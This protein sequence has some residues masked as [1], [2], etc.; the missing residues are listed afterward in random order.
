MA[1]TAAEVMVVADIESK[2]WHRYAPLIGQVNA[3]L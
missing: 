2:L 1:E 3:T